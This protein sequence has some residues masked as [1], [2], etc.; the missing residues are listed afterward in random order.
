MGLML[1]ISA[2][3]TINFSASDIQ[4]WVGTGSNQ[5]VVVIGWDDNPSGSNFALAWGVRWNGSCTA[6]N[7]LDTIATYDSRV[8]YAISSGFV[9]SIGYNDGTLVSGS[10]DS[11]WCYTLNGGYAGAYSTQAMA[12]GDIME[13]SS[14]CLFTLSTA[15]AATNMHFI[16][17]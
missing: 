5:A 17:S 16:S 12:N 3:A 2:S 6:V 9:T 8:A 13:I 11:Y 1:A 15:M 14:S 4:Y 7:M 10:S